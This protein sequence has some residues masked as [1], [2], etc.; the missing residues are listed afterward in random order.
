MD[1]I[2]KP[3]KLRKFLE[4]I[5]KTEAKNIV[6]TGD[7]SCCEIH[8]RKNAPKLLVHLEMISKAAGPD[9]MVYF[10]L[11]NHDYWQTSIDQVRKVISH[12]HTN[13]PV[14]YSNLRWLGASA[15]IPL[16]N[17]TVLVGHD[18]WYDGRNGDTLGLLRTNSFMN[19]WWKIMDFSEAMLGGIVHDI[20]FLLS[21]M[22]RLADTGTEFIKKNV[23]EAINSGFKKIVIATH[24]P[25]FAESALDSR[26]GR[27]DIFWVGLYSNRL[28]GIEL[29]DIAQNHPE[30]EILILCGHAHSGCT[31]RKDNVTCLTGQAEYGSPKQQPKINQILHQKTNGLW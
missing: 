19:D 9:R 2:S 25:P 21:T 13:M 10:V 11:G 6:I 24:F 26:K 4:S 17:E 18:G 30:I 16:N 3:K 29:L 20:P 31:Y 22:E 1:A 12:F 27:V 23:L 5:E 28:L 7:I 14:R 15:P 8:P